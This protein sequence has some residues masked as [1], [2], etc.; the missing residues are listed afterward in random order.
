MSKI[1]VAKTLGLCKSPGALGSHAT[2]AEKGTLI[3][4]GSLDCRESGKK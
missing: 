2:Q 4:Y 3:I 1:K